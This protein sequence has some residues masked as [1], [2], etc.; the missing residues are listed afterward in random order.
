MHRRSTSTPNR[1]CL[2]KGYLEAKGLQICK[3]DAPGAIR[4]S[5]GQAERLA[6]YP[7]THSQRDFDS[8]L[9][10]DTGEDDSLRHARALARDRRRAE[11]HEVR[12]PCP[13]AANQLRV[14]GSTSG[15]QR[16]RPQETQR[17]RQT[18]LQEAAAHAEARQLA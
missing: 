2:A 17:H 4:T 7:S 8:T 1:C 12:K 9:L 16:P 14:W 18:F 13:L 15:S 11:G 5:T 3:S 10:D 6:A